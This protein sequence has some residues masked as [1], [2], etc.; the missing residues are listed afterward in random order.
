M[1]PNVQTSITALHVLPSYCLP[2]GDLSSVLQH[3]GRFDEDVARQYIAET[4]LAL[5]YCHSKGIIHRD[6]KPDNLLIS[7]TGNLI[8]VQEQVTILV[9]CL[10]FC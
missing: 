1:W 8:I 3:L 4:V 10:C 5:E 7:Q 6:L 2:G 9:C